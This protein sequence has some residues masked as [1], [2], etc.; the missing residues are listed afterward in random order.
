MDRSARSG[1][2]NA[3]PG[4]TV[5]STVLAGLVLAACAGG[6]PL[7]A[8]PSTASLPTLPVL[9]SEQEALSI[10][11]AEAYSRIAAGANAC[12]F[13]GRGRIARSHIF[14]ADAA[15]RMSGGAV[16]I[17]VHERAVDQPKPWGYKAFRI[18]LTESHGIDGA[19][20]EG[21]SRLVVEN[22][23]F[24]HGPAQRMRAEVFQWAKGNPDCIADPEADAALAAAAPPP[25]PPKAKP[26]VKRPKSAAAAK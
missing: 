21:G 13:G 11:S 23:R 20:G 10:G 3:R 9:S 18:A 2:Q 24:E 4:V 6:P 26:A 25:P 7:P 15:S 16:E 22:L 14:H 1:Q 12:W 8:L 5:L 17:I 19:P